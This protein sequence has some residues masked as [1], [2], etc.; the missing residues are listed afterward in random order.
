MSEDGS[1]AETVDKA[2][3]AKVQT[4]RS[5]SIIW[6]VPIVALIIGG[7]LAYKA[8]SEKG[9]TLTIT[10]ESA[11]GLVAGKTKFKYKDVEIG[12]VSAIDLLDDLSGVVV[13]AEMV[14]DFSAYMTEKTSFWVVRARVAAGEVSGLGTILSGAYIG[15]SPSDKGQPV[16]KFAGLEKPPVMTEGLP[17][18]HFTLHS[19]TLGSLDVGSPILYRGIKVGQVVDY[20]FDEA[21][22]SIIFKIFIDAPFHEKVRENSRFWNAS[23]ID[24]TMDASG[25]KMDTQSL[26][27]ILLGGVAFDNPLDVKPGGQAEESKRFELYASR[28]ESR[29]VKY[30]YREQ[31]LLYF[32]QSVRGLS[33]GAPVEIKG[34]KIGE[35]VSIELQYD[36]GLVNFRVPVLIMIEPERLNAVI[37]EEGERLT[38]SEMG[39]EI[40]ETNDE[41]EGRLHTKIMIRKGLRAQ[42][43]TGNLL[44]GQLYIDF[45]FYPDAA[46]AELKEQDGV[47]V[48]PTVPVPLKRIIQRVDNILEQVEQVPF[49]QMGKDVG[50]V[51]KEVDV[52]VQNLNTLFKDLSSVSVNVNEATLPKINGMIDELQKTLKGAD[53][54]LKGID[55]TL[56]QDSSLNYSSLKVL[57]ELS[58]TIRSL[59]S[60]LDYLE[61]DPQA[62]ILGK[63]G[64]KK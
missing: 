37:T 31:F 47:L 19:E 25:I 52:A 57:D 63:E 8:K 64:E 11:E 17:G 36:Q 27:S 32:D 51:V 10:F 48:F 45:D 61:R 33:P 28:D 22:E 54:T 16:K 55:A 50:V 60:L 13:T 15:C 18:R 35:V 6:V 7:W 4:K 9:P 21:A 30:K 58:M 12:V 46:P 2:P 14:K 62:L 3:A 40:D 23:G 59:R 20:D 24:F 34:I 41:G 53:A 39:A 42:L 43:K 29:N 44:T 56:G 26:V 49:A 5:F 38:G 1:R